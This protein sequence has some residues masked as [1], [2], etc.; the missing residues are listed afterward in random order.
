MKL[1]IDDRE[2]ESLSVALTDAK[3]KTSEHAISVSALVAHSSAS[4][5]HPCERCRLRRHEHRREKLVRE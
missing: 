1:T 4:S 2:I 5:A 3:G